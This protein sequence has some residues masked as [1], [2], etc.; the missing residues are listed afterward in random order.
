M[1]YRFAARMGK[2]PRSFIREILRVTE[3]RSIISFAG[4]LPNPALFPVDAIKEAAIDVLTEKPTEALQYSTTEGYLPLREWI[5]ERYQK[6]A[7][8]SIPPEN[9]LI[10]NGSQQSL[11]LIGKICIDKKSPVAIEKPGYLGAIQAFSLYEP[12]FHPVGLELDGPD[13]ACLEEIVRR[14]SPQIFYGVPNFQ[15]P[16]GITYSDEKRREVGEMLSGTDTLFIEDDAYG[17]L[18]FRGDDLP[19]VHQFLPENGIILGSFSKIIAPGMRMG[20]IAAPPEIYEKL[21]TAKQASDLHSNY[22]SQLIIHQ[23][24]ASH[25][26]E[27]HL[28]LIRD[29]YR[30]QRD[31]MVK[32]MEEFFPQE[33]TFT[34]PDG[35]MF[36][37]ATLPDGISSIDLFELA[38]RKKVAFVPGNPFYTDG[39]GSS[40]L[41]LNYS[42]AGPDS[43]IEGIR[44]LGEAMK[45]LIG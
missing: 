27:S 14:Y 40:S 2:T 43:I 13:I 39:G 15:N 6:R 37:W 28:R 7:G 4:G 33:V 30:R 8:L 36:L 45:S 21:I 17:E 34:R 16:S 35:G 9:I 44:R 24:L 29:S 23:F 31:C 26:I 19:L 38:I 12:Q 32:A 11:D 42:N 41:R 25:D 3:D 1:A 5:S 20:W 10:T 18:R 22:L